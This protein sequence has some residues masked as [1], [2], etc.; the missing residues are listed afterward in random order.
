VITAERV[1]DLDFA[2]LTGLPA[3]TLPEGVMIRDLAAMSAAIQHAPADILPPGVAPDTT[4]REL[5]A[6][7][8]GAAVATPSPVSYV[9]A[10]ATG[11][12][13]V[14]GHLS[15]FAKVNGVLTVRGFRGNLAYYTGEMLP[16]PP[17]R[18]FSQ[19]L[20]IGVPGGFVN[21]LAFTKMPGKQTAIYVPVDVDTATAF[22]DELKA[23][24]FK[25]PYKYSAPKPDAKPGGKE[26]RMRQFL[27]AKGGEP[28]AVV[29]GNNCI[30]VP[31]PQIEAAIGMRPQVD[32][33]GGRLDLTTGRIGQ[34]PVD[35]HAKGRASHMR[36]FV[37]KPDLSKAKPGA[38]RIG[39][40]EGAV[41]AMGAVRI[42]GGIWMIYG[43]IQ[44]V[45]RLMEAWG[46]DQFVQ[47]AAEEAGAWGGGLAGGALGGAIAA[48]IGESVLLVAGGEVTAMFVVGGFGL[49]LGL[50]Y[51]GAIA[52]ATL[53][54]AVFDAP[55]V[56]VWGT[57]TA[58]DAFM[59]ANIVTGNFIHGMLIHTMLR[60]M[61]VA[62]ERINPANW[63]L[64]GLPP[65]AANAVRNLGMAAWSTLGSLNAD[66]LRASAGQTFAQLGVPPAAAADVARTFVPAG[67]RI[68]GENILSRTPL[69]FVQ[70][71]IK[72]KS[73]DFVQDPEVLA[74]DAL[75][76]EGHKPDEAYLNVHL[77]PMIATR[78]RINPNN[79]DLR[80]VN[81]GAGAG[82]VR[83]V[84]TIVWRQ[85]QSLKK[86]EF[87][88]ASRKSLAQFGVSM[89][90][91]LAATKALTKSKTLGGQQIE[92]EEV[93]ADIVAEY[94]AQLR[95]MTPEDFA[96]H[97]Q[98]SAGLR[99]HSDP[100]SIA[101]AALHWLRAGYQPW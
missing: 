3:D 39:M 19:K 5:N 29:C 76:P 26:W 95:E 23:T 13:W 64:R 25:E 47:T 69:D 85:L 35:P 6:A 83:A 59:E 12:M 80:A 88:P 71:L 93:P 87:G 65:D 100:G 97:L 46:T 49:A 101:N 7:V 84:G 82:D 78:A 36:D 41:K 56:M 86:E 77:A 21:D 92:D 60:P 9:P 33:K 32:T 58:L 4:T 48:G 11:I 27:I 72:T 17:G 10:N 31:A 24:E 44:S 15:I 43:G 53:V 52:G 66:E 91:M 20:N 18:W 74:D 68:T 1:S 22:R 62:R 55:N 96:Y 34:G 63:D 98:E 45:G 30:T 99:F 67:I 50:G 51:L 2:Q 54:Q 70:Y 16:G 90:A 94:A 57:V 73:L 42:G 89:E 81:A 28:M 14:Q 79:W 38:T 40:T 37:D 61:V 75:E 8:A